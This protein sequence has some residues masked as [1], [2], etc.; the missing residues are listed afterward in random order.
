MTYQNYRPSDTKTNRFRLP[1]HVA[2]GGVGGDG[3]GAA[4]ERRRREIRVQR[5]DG[6]ALG[7]EVAGGGE[8]ERAMAAAR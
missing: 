5:T 2:D 7:Q 3:D 8:T 1:R 6:I 4:G